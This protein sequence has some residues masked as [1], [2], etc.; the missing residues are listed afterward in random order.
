MRR[1]ANQGSR[2]GA[3]RA[4]DPVSTCARR[5][6]G[7]VAV[8]AMVVVVLGRPGP[9]IAQVS[10]GPLARAH[11]E[12]DG[13]LD[14]MKCHAKGEKGLDGQCLA[15]HREI[16]ATRKARTGLHGKARLEGCA[17]CHPDHA[18]EDFEM[19]AWEEGS[20]EK[21]DHAKTTFLL[22]GKHRSLEC[23]DCHNAKFSVSPIAALA[24]GKDRSR[25]FIGLETA[26][27]SCHADPHRGALG[28]NCTSCHGEDAWKP[29]TGFDHQGSTYPLTGKHEKVECDACHRAE[30]LKTP[31]AADG[32][33]EALWK[34]LA[35]GECSDCH[36]D[37]HRDRLGPACTTCHVTESFQ[38]TDRKLFD[39]D[40][41]RYP[42]RG[43]HRP[44]ECARCHDEKKAWG[45]KP[46]FG[47]CTDCHEEAHGKAV[48]LGGKPADCSACHSVERFQPSTYTTVMHAG[49]D[50]A[51]KGAHLRVACDSCHPRVKGS[52]A[53]G[54]GT[55]AVLLRPKHGDC[56][57]CHADPHRGRF[58]TGG[59]RPVEKGCLGC[60][61][62]EAFRPARFELDDHSRSAFP[63]E[64]AHRTVPCV[65]CHES[66]RR[67]GAGR[68]PWR[69]GA[70]PMDFRERFARCIDCHDNPH[71][72][73]FDDR[74]DRG[75]CRSCHGI[76]A[77]V[78]A[79][80]FDH[81]TL[82]AFPLS[83]AHAGVACAKCH[84]ERTNADGKR[85]VVY[86]PIA[87]Q[88]QDCHVAAVPA[89]GGESR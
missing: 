57:D 74:V 46:R 63:L 82:P 48:S 9:A 13:P 66:L 88:C 68:A 28:E 42:L 17:R 75:E 83:G 12:L 81:V 70:S 18:G 55:A 59:D 11:A 26:C 2:S 41:T 21:F 43:R 51:L 45:E 25:G 19:I 34:P 54:L 56:T 40:R 49:A 58:A 44:L 20:R 35:H 78:P 47:K 50:Y 64:G 84:P 36:E 31:P 71:G 89:A 14:C 23:R 77:F 61:S 87:H 80:A 67:A 72:A 3:L 73:Q 7:T 4:S 5:I 24:P 85:E 86:R 76:E 6:V 52:A 32:K 22:R 16:A 33:R 65:D 29:A 27:V 69:A 38:K 10:P 62:L 8:L 79:E 37:P 39:H 60:H 53:A 30:R 15:C 1:N